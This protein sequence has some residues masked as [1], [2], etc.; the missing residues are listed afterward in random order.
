MKVSLL[1]FGQ[2]RFCS[3]EK[4]KKFLSEI[5]TKYNA[6]V[7]AHLWFEK[8]SEYEVS[9]WASNPPDGKGIIGNPVPGN[10]VE[11]IQKTYNPK[12]IKVDPP[13]TF[14]LKSETLN[15]IR[16]NWSGFHY[17]EKNYSNIKSQLTSIG[18]VARLYES[19]G[20]CHDLYLLC[21]YD[22]WAVEFPNLLQLSSNKF[23][24][25][26]HHP[27]FPDIIQICGKKFF[28]WM[29]N[30][31]DDMD[32]ELVYKTIWEPSPEAFKMKSFL[33]RH[34]TDDIVGLPMEGF[35]IRR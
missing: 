29:K 24:V 22:S 33:L 4:P 10:S 9:T 18:E 30:C 12:K 3:D 1:L 14:K 34:S 15:F 25:A 32:N 13:K 20:D 27:N 35:V 7:Y 17:N 31:A 26:N 5:I 8:N 28:D 19:S 6:D 11:I 16:N 2:P 21:R 23:Y